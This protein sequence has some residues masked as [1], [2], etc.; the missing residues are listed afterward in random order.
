MPNGCA[1][2]LKVTYSVAISSAGCRRDSI[3][4]QED[5]VDGLG[6]F[7][8][9]VELIGGVLDGFTFNQD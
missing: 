5:P 2:F 8:L 7:V 9:E 3:L 4:L 1:G 6:V